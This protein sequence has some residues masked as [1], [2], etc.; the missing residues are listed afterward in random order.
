MSSVVPSAAV[1]G[2]LANQERLF[3]QSIALSSELHNRSV[4]QTVRQH[5]ERAEL[6]DVIFRRQQSLERELHYREMLHAV[7][8][9]RREAQRDVWSQK[10][11]IAQALMTVDTVVFGSAFSLA[12]EGTSAPGTSKWLNRVYST[13]CALALGT[14]FFSMWA[15]VK[16]Q[17]RMQQYDMRGG[18]AHGTGVGLVGSRYK[19]GKVH[20]SFTDYFHCHCRALEVTAFNT[21]YIGL[22]FTVL[23]GTLLA[24]SLFTAGFDKPYYSPVI[25][26]CAVCLVGFKV[27]ILMMKDSVKKLCVSSL[28]RKDT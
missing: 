9:G 27:P 17:K 28:N 15:T 22:S 8:A 12:V 7:E 1:L 23:S 25:V 26:F 21:F 6:E 11:L 16:L 19:C 4:H 5:E 24:A 10:A 14:L 18:E 2:P 3:T 13:T 20:T